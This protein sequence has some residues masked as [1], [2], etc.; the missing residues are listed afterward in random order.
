[1]SRSDC[2]SASIQ[3]SKKY[4]DQDFLHAQFVVQQKSASDIAEL[5]NV[6]RSTIDMWLARHDIERSPRYQNRDWLYIEY[7]QKRRNQADIA[8]ECGVTKATICHWLAKL[9]ITQG[10][11]FESSTCV[12][13]NERFWYYPSLRDGNYCSNKCSNKHRQNQASLVCPNCD[14]EFRRRRSLGIQYWSLECW[15]DEYGV[16]SDELYSH[17]WT[18]IREKALERDEYQCT[19]CGISDQK[20]RTQF[21]FGLDVHHEVPVRLFAKWDQPIGDAHTLRNL[22]AVWRT[23]HPDAPGYTVRSDQKG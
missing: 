2:D 17:G 12:E 9:G 11:S 19:V 10:E 6:A 20:H 22:R 7:V 16:D 15:G 1:V 5:C 4:R 3:Q 21:G 8:A 13:C 18:R 23:H 14:T